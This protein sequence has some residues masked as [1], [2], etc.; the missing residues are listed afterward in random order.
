MRSV[1]L[2]PF[3]FLPNYIKA[4]LPV[5]VDI[6]NEWI[7][8]RLNSYLSKRS[9]WGKDLDVI[10]DQMKIQWIEDSQQARRISFQLFECYSWKRY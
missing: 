6:Q 8:F 5:Y 4:S 2:I 10:N 1:S 7:L 3:G 9:V